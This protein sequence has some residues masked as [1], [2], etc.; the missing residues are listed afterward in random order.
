M[1]YR[2][3]PVKI[4][5]LDDFKEGET[6]TPAQLEA[7]AT[8]FLKKDRRDSGEDHNILFVTLVLNG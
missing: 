2:K 4:S 1:W 5:D 7:F 3:K 6:Y 8:A